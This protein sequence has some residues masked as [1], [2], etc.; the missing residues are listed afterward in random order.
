MGEKASACR[1]DLLPHFSVGLA[2]SMRVGKPAGEN[3]E[4]VIPDERKS[5]RK[6]GKDSR[7]ESRSLV[8]RKISRGK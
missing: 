2:D 3:P 1:L 8:R 7:L 5:V 4:A 6:G